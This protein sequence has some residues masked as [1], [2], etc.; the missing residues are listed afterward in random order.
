MTPNRSTDRDSCSQFGHR[1]VG[2]HF[3]MAAR[4]RVDTPSGNARCRR[5]PPPMRERRRYGWT[6]G[7][8]GDTQPKQGVTQPGGTGG[9]GGPRASQKRFVKQSHSGESHRSGC[10]A[11]AAAECVC[12]TVHKRGAARSSV[13][14]H[15][16]HIHSLAPSPAGHST[17]PRAWSARSS[18]CPHTRP[19][20]P[21]PRYPL[22]PIMAH[23]VGPG[24]LVDRSLPQ[25]GVSIR[26]L[27]RVVAA[28]A[29]AAATFGVVCT[30]LVL[31][32]PAASDDS[33]PLAAVG[34][35][36]RAEASVRRAEEPRTVAGH[37]VNCTAGNYSTTTLKLLAEQP[38]AALLAGMSP[39]SEPQWATAPPSLS[40]FE[41]S[42]VSAVAGSTDMFVI[43]DNTYRIGRVANG[44]PS[45]VAGGLAAAA[46]GEEAPPSRFITWPGDDGADSEFESITY[47]TTSGHYL[48]M[49]EAVVNGSGAL[50]TRILEVSLDGG[51]ATVHSTCDGIMAF[52]SA[53][54]GME[55]AAIATAADGN[56][57]LLGLCEGNG[58]AKGKAG[59]KPGGGR[60]VVMQRVTTAA[61]GCAWVPVQTVAIPP[62]AAFQ[63]YAAISIFNNSRV[64]VLSQEN[65]AVWVGDLDL[66]DGGTDSNGQRSLF[67]LSGDT[68]FDF[69]RNN[70]CERIYCNVE[71]IHWQSPDTLIAV[72]DMMKAGGK[73]S[74]VCQDHDQSIH[75]F[76]VPG[77][78][79]VK[80]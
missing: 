70:R 2:D 20:L 43:F 67:G 51:E 24:P 25:L 68:V 26:V 49:Q 58:C 60:V 73:Q 4:A 27:W 33:S 47:N 77:R 48:I 1:R 12:S 52:E 29:V 42:G 65:A 59:R 15:P 36:H 28:T 41:A 45:F 9:G 19:L 21:R 76:Q 23:L 39:A 64:A 14:A 3:A 78:V 17:L 63:D 8:H 57:Y 55:G 74:F 18:L 34:S 13:L 62:S 80:E 79:P 50:V 72:S 71:G 5:V 56:S 31:Q 7:P 69:P 37:D 35:L 16:C 32:G 46:A 11:A 44:V 38:L 22:L 53:N 75:T 30:T 40:H 61:C 54:K 66:L 10:Q 6:D